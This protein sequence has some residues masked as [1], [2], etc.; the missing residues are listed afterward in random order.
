MSTMGFELA[1]PDAAT[2][3]RHIPEA[4]T[5]SFKAGDV[6]YL[7]SGLVTVAAADSSIYGVA[8][9]DATTATTGVI[10]VV[11]IDDTQD[12]ISTV[13]TTS[14]VTNKGVAYGLTISTKG[15]MCVD[16]TDTTTTS[17]RVVDLHPADGAKALG[18]VIVRFLNAVLQVA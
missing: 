15:S 10:P 4:A 2:N 13:G 18:R 12:W 11:V 14:A 16:L 7:V 8:L 6:V 17:V 3:I 5:Q 1:H 9:K